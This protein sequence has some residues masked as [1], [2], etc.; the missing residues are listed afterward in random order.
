MRSILLQVAEG[1][2]IAQDPILLSGVLDLSLRCTS[3]CCVLGG[4]LSSVSDPFWCAGGDGGCSAIDFIGVGGLN[5][6]DGGCSAA[7]GECGEAPCP[8]EGGAAAGS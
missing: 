2:E 1:R 8:I 3:A 6:G 7:G 5:G 4:V